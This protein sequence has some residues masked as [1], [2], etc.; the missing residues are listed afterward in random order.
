[1]VVYKQFKISLLFIDAF[2]IKHDCYYNNGHLLVVK[3]D[4]CLGKHAVNKRR[5]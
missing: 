3:A 1:M 2:N 4:G 5:Q